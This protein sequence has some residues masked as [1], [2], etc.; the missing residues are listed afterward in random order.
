MPPW[1]AIIFRPTRWNSGKYEPT[2]SESTRH[3]KPRSLAS[4]TVVCTQTSVVTPVTMSCVMPRSARTSLELGRVER[5]LAGLVEH[6][7]ALD[8]RELVDDL[9]AGL[10]ADEDAAVRP[11][12]ADPLEVAARSLLGGR[13]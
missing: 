5:A 10:A 6:D 11:L 2:Q 12:V 4:R 8:R 3:S 13:R 7:L 9:V 1:A